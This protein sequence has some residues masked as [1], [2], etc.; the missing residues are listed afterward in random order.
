MSNSTTGKDSE[1]QS[2]HSKNAALVWS[3]MSEQE[4]I[5]FFEQALRE[6]DLHSETYPDYHYT[7]I[8]KPNGNGSKTAKQTGTSSLNSPFH[9]DFVPTSE[10]PELELTPKLEVCRSLESLPKWRQP[11]VLTQQPSSSQYDPSF[12]HHFEGGPYPFVPQRHCRYDSGDPTIPPL[13][14]SGGPTSSLLC[15]NPY[16]SAHY[17]AAASSLPYPSG[18]HRG[19]H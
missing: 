7:P 16:P 2:Q 18:P 10:I 6:K 1:L 5:P 9:R 15:D 8:R 4:K 11:N 17:L 13:P 14:R 3:G 12:Y 19:K